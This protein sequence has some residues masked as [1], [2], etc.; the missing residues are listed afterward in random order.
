MWSFI[1]AAVGI[2]GIYLAGKKNK[3]G[4]AI[5]FGTQALWII[6]AIATKQYGFI[7]SA[8]AY[9]WVYGKNYVAW[10]KKDAEV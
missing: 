6:F 8:L 2:F 3:Y 5:G 7:F 4:W 1:L 10:N 9:G